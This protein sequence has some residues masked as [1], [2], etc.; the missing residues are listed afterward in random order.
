MR[1]NLRPPSG[2][3]TATDAA[4]DLTSSLRERLSRQAGVN[5][6]TTFFLPDGNMNRKQ[7]PSRD[8]GDN[9]CG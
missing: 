1:H 6:Q 7:H 5:K 9:T 8:I 3:A 4:R 2:F